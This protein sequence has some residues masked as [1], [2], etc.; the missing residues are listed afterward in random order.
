MDPDA[1]LSPIHA[2][3]VSLSRYVIRP[4]S[5]SPQPSPLTD[6]R[7]LLGQGARQDPTGSEHADLSGGD[8]PITGPSGDPLG[9]DSRRR[10]SSDDETFT[11]SGGG[12]KSSNDN[13]LTVLSQ[14]SAVSAPP[15]VRRAVMGCSGVKGG[16]G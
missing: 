6:E 11:F 9:A 8:T 13:D 2:I 16:R 14:D 1:P 15:Q 7:K 3:V 4:S 12:R 10:A 5:L